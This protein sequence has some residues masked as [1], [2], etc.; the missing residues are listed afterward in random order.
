MIHGLLPMRRQYVH[1]SEDK[2]TAKIVAG[3]RKNSVTKVLTVMARQA[4]DEGTPFYKEENGIW[5]SDPLLPKY[6]KLDLV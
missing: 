2:A 6:I 1:L 3:R 5:L 4:Y